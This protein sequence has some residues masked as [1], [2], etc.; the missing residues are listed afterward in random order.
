M[1]YRNDLVMYEIFIV[2]DRSMQRIEI[3]QDDDTE[4]FTALVKVSTGG[5]A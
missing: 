3:V 1:R 2:S 5:N 4:I